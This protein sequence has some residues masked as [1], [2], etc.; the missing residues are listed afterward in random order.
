ML[1]ML[2]RY[3][4]HLSGRRGALVVVFALG[5][6]GAA[7]SLSTPLLGMAFVDAVATR[8]DFTSIPWIAVAQTLDAQEPFKNKQAL[9]AM[10]A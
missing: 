7:V 3:T 6:A 2:R 9:I 5:L 1:T 4:P 10:P 8:H